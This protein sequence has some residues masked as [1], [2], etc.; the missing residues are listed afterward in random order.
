LDTKHLIERSGRQNKKAIV[1]VYGDWDAS[2]VM[3]PRWLEH[4]VQHAPGSFYKLETIEVF[5]G[6][7]VV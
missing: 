1:L 5:I 6:N 7:R 3:L 4:M 2:F